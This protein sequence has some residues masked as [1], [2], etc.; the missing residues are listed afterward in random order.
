MSD[1]ISASALK[2]TLEIT[3]TDWDNDISVAIP[4]STEVIDNYKKTRFWTTD[5]DETRYFASDPC[6]R[7]VT[8]NP[9]LSAFTGASADYD[10]DGVYETAWAYGTDFVLAPANAAL[11]GQPYNELRLRRRY[12]RRLPCGEEAVAITGRY[13]WATAPSVVVQAAM[14]LAGRWVKRAR[15]TPYGILTITGDAVAA[16]RLGK[17]DPDVE[18]LLENIPGRE[19]RPFA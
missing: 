17:I 8:I 3:T 13:G 16:A 19:R 18:L 4:A 2:T 15:E 5:A 10:D 7:Y 1:Y 6:D 11:D 12:G 14:I 9:D